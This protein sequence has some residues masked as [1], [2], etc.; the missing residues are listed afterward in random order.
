MVVTLPILLFPAAQ[1]T[2]MSHLR[3]VP[4]ALGEN[5][6]RREVLPGYR[7]HFVGR[8]GGMLLNNMQILGLFCWRFW[9]SRSEG[10]LESLGFTGAPGELSARYTGYNWVQQAWNGIAGPK[11]L[12]H[13]LRRDWSIRPFASSTDCVFKT[14]HLQSVLSYDCLLYV[15]KYLEMLVCT[16]FF[17]LGHHCT[18]IW[19]PLFPLFSLTTVTLPCGYFSFS[20][21][22]SQ[23][24]RWLGWWC[25]VFSSGPR[26][27]HSL[28]GLGRESCA[29]DSREWW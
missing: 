22:S 2:V 11:V 14:Q 24:I 6:S 1:L 26:L 27:C 3:C 5:F 9:L 13:L 16:I 25:E 4:A 10:A 18:F 12:Q 17:S 23:N 21:L 28:S 20:G 29:Y 15:T 7:N 19:H 8:E